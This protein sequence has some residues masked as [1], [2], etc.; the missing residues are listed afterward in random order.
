MWRRVTHRNIQDIHTAFLASGML[1][2]LDMTV[3]G[4]RYINCVPSQRFWGM[5]IV[6]AVLITVA[7]QIWIGRGT[8]PNR[9]LAAFIGH[10]LLFSLYAGLA[11]EAFLSLEPAA[12]GQLAFAILY[13]SMAVVHRAFIHGKSDVPE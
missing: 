4:V 11:A 1:L 2:G 7:G 5:A 3:R 10:L 6:A 8:G 13:A 12:N 9:W